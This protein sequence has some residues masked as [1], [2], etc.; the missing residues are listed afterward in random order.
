MNIAAT[1]LWKIFNSQCS[2]PDALRI[3]KYN[4]GSIEKHLDDLKK[5]DTHDCSNYFNS[6]MQVK[7]AAYQGLVILG[8]IDANKIMPL[9]GDDST[10]E[11][12]MGICGD[13][14]YYFL[15]NKWNIII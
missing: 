4:D 10:R 15:N 12:D 9:G 11:M 7:M 3:L 5:S 14:Q 2:L 13:K 1:D 8:E 6:C